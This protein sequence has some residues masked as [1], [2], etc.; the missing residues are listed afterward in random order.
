M[1]KK[2][3]PLPASLIRLR[4]QFEDWRK[5]RTQRRIPERLWSAAV[6]E[7]QRHGV[8]RTARTLRLNDQSLRERAGSAPLGGEASPVA[9]KRSAAFVEVVPEQITGG[10]SECVVEIEDGIGA[11]LRVQLRGEILPALESLSRCFLRR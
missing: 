11:R 5:T 9:S 10:R 4:Q 8:Y 2:R 3:S 6:K 1:A 7:A